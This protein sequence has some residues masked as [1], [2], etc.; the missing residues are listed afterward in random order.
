MYTRGFVECPPDTDAATIAAFTNIFSK[1]VVVGAGYAMVSSPLTGLEQSRSSTW[2]TVARE[3]M[4]PLHELTGRR[5]TGPVT[6]I[7]SIS[8]D[9]RATPGLYTNSPGFCVLQ[10]DRGYG[11]FY[12]TGAPLQ[13]PPGS[14]FYEFPLGAVMDEACT[15]SMQALHDF[16]NDTERVT[17]AGDINETDAQ[18][19]ETHINAY[20]RP[21]LVGGNN[22]YQAQDASDFNAQ[23]VRDNDILS[24]EQLQVTLTVTP[25]GYNRS[26][27][28]TITY[29]NPA[30]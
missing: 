5:A 21:I 26:I 13:A 9:E 18:N 28:A 24:T 22:P 27:S 11:G 19:I 2:V 16:L 23:V 6:G 8:R 1:R 29:F 7:T 30:L 4:I 3:M 10:T 25:V 14:D 17:A 15:L 20:V 12:I